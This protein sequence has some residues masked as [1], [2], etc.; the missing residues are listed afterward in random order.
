MIS[1]TGIAR[2]G[3]TVIVRTLSSRSSQKSSSAAMVAAVRNLESRRSN[4]GA[5]SCSLHMEFRSYR[6]ILFG[7]M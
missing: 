4:F 7:G 2:A 1:E 5:E 6:N 3:S